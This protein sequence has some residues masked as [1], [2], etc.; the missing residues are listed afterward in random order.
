M[1]LL[2]HYPRF[3]VHARDAKI[4]KDVCVP[5]IAVA[6][7]M[8][9]LIYFIGDKIPRDLSP[10]A[11]TAF[12]DFVFRGIHSMS[13][14]YIMLLLM[15]MQVLHTLMCVPMLHLSQMLVGFFFG[16]GV[17]F[18]V[19]AL[20]E[21]LL[22]CVFAWYTKRVVAAAPSKSEET[23]ILATYIATCRVDNLYFFSIICIIMSS[24]PLNSSVSLVVFGGVP[25]RDFVATH[26]VVTFFM[27]AKNVY[28][29]SVI[30]D[31][32]SAASLDLCLALMG[33]FTVIPSIFTLYITWSVYRVARKDTSTIGHIQDHST[34]NMEK[35]ENA[36]SV[37]TGRL[38]EN[39]CD[40]SLT[41]TECSSLLDKDGA[42]TKVS[43]RIT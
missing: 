31:E 18:P 28:I 9:V 10:E 3:S 21:C 25:M 20:W 29:G 14:I 41:S 19:S 40:P 6:F 11:W 23:N 17:G 1:P 37:V 26:I 34:S 35:A 15:S 42:I 36:E 5:I 43:E 24:I 39:D 12:S 13:P 22:V 7:M 30:K 4:L 8:L 33:V 2:R 32:P 38:P 16:M 27:T